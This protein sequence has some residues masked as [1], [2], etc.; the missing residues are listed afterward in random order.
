MRKRSYVAVVGSLV[1][2]WSTP[3]Y[4]QYRD[5]GTQCYV[6]PFTA[7]ARLSVFVEGAGA[8][9]QWGVST[10]LHFVLAN[11]Q[12]SKGF[13][14]GGTQGLFAFDVLG[15]QGTNPDDGGN[16][17]PDRPSFQNI[18]HGDAGGYLAGGAVYGDYDV[19]EVRH[20]PGIGAPVFGCN[21]TPSGWWTSKPGNLPTYTCGDDAWL[22]WN[23]QL[24][25]TVTLSKDVAI[26]YLWQ[27][28]DDTGTIV[29]IG[30]CVSD[31]TCVTATPEP[32]TLVLMGTGLG[33]VAI[34]RRRGR[35]RG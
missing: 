21:R 15:A 34:V 4:G 35:R 6:G 10:I 32:V 7:C 29:T 23:V 31:L 22:E 18:S 28:W 19:F 1:C 5:F 27:G 12:G 3:G 26:Q 11:V 24:P 13:D 14:Y 17:I 2:L 30:S 25:G 20:D 8:Y 9:R 16:D 33:A